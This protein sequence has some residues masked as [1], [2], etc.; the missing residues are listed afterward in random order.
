MPTKAAFDATGIGKLIID[1]A[2]RRAGIVWENIRK[3][4][5]IYIRGFA[6]T[7]ADVAAGVVKGEITKKDAAMF[8]RNAR[9]LLIM[10]IAN[11]TQTV[12][13]QVQAFMDSV[14]KA[15]KSSIN[16]ALPIAIL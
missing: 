7:L 6:Q 4:A 15:V 9:L 2:I 5:P 11:T 10:G 16:G 13:V 1:E 3:A 8:V 12:L 14:L